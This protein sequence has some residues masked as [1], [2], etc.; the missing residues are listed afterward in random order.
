MHMKNLSE[1]NNNPHISW[2]FGRMGVPHYGHAALIKTL[3]ATAKGGAWALFLS[4]SHDSKKNPLEYDE[5]L[6]WIYTLFP[7]TQGHV[8]E[9]KSIRTFLEAASYLYEKGFRSAT[10]VAGE[11]DIIKMK[12]TLLEY[13]GKETASGYYNFEP[14]T[15]MPAPRLTS[16]T[17]AREAAK[18]GDM[19]AFER[20]THVSPNI[21]VNNKTLFQTVR[22]GMG[23]RN[24]IEE[25]STTKVKTEA[26]NQA[27]NINEA[28]DQPYPAIEIKRTSAGTQYQFKTDS[29]DTTL[30]SLVKEILHDGSIRI[31]VMFAD[32]SG[33]EKSTEKTGKGDAFRIFATVSKVVNDYIT[34]SKTPISEITFSGKTKDPSRIKLYDRIAQRLGQ[35]VPGFKFKGAGEDGVEKVYYFDRTTSVTETKIDNVNGWG[36]VPDNQNIDYLGLR[37]NMKPSV[38]LKLA[39]KLGEPKSTPEIVTHLN[40]GGSIGAPFLKFDI[41]A[42]W[43]NHQF[44]EPANIVGHE[45]RNRMMA[46]LSTAG[47]IPTEVHL[48]PRGKRHRHLTNDI[49]KKL[50]LGMNAENSS[51]FVSGPLFAL[52]AKDNIDESQLDEYK[53]DTTAYGGWIL[54]NR[55]VEYVE[56]YG[57]LD[58]LVYGHNMPNS[59]SSYE[60]AFNQGFVRF[61]T[62]EATSE[63]NVAG[64]LEN[65]RKTYRVWADTAMSMSNVY[66]DIINYK[67]EYQNEGIDRSMY[68][69]LPESKSLLIKLFGPESIKRVPVQTQESAE[70]ATKAEAKYQPM[71]RNK[72]RCDDC[73]MFRPP[74]GCTAVMGKIA[75]NGWCTFFEKAKNK[76][77]ENMDHTKDSEAVAELKAALLSRKKI[78]Q[79]KSEDDVYN[80]IDKIMTRIAKAHGLTGQ[81]IHDMWVKKYGE[82]PDTWIMNE[83]T[84]INEAATDIVFHYTGVHSALEILKTGDFKLSSA[85]GSVE[86]KYAPR[87]K[88]YFLSTTRSKVGGYHHYTGS[89]AVMFVLNG[90]WLNQRYQ[91]KPIDYWAGFA[92]PT[93]HNESE[94]RVWSNEPFIPITPI[95]AIHILLKE[96]N[97]FQSPRVRQLMI[98]GKTRG[99][100]TYLY[101]DENAWRLQNIRNS[102][103][104]D[105]IGDL[106]KGTSPA[107][108][109]RRGTRWLKPWL[110]L[111]YHKKRTEL[112][113]KAN[114]MR[115]S[116]TYWNGRDDLGLKTDLSNARKPGNDDYEDAVKLVS[117]MR[118][119]KIPDLKTFIQY[120]ANK[121]D[122]E[123]QQK[124]SV[125]EH[126][127]GTLGTVGGGPDMVDRQV[128]VDPWDISGNYPSEKR[129]VSFIKN[130]LKK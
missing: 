23:L 70:K 11:D 74:H 59:E 97:E 69:R 83:S 64:L 22:D 99:I 36:A 26:M 19:E 47:D 38:F 43:N 106:L 111:I 128:A 98:A 17:N 49:I 109:Q 50:N 127:T 52:T 53:L 48:F 44:N 42:D 81:E 119:N 93:R 75:P 5:K 120:L 110:E 121:W 78:L 112:S 117:W 46:I 130:K 58:H 18:A 95:M 33:Q 32:Q 6:Q 105:Q 79:K 116:L 107:S 85:A 16:S 4:K 54:P 102:V 51:T 37:V 101:I 28:G 126:E 1:S 30:I 29:G 62:N 45:G 13:N 8:V 88:N 104:I 56:K 92:N 55:K 40:S 7:H 91:V 123:A 2:A 65:I 114:Q 86:E 122:A 100:P 41:P 82:I 96:Q 87:G 89:S 15:F 118:K 24:N 25:S 27:K 21:T 31:E 129:G 57:H 12:K 9:D 103:S 3:T 108:Y 63:M 113:K 61:Q 10:F 67:D 124:E 115:Y 60:T 77:D 39:S 14:L 90:R 20:A 125:E 84:E 72:Q 80:T 35:Y 68:F 73:T 71:P 66:I 94:D 34:K 76:F